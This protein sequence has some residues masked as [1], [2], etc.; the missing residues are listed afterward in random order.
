[1]PTEEE[2]NRAAESDTESKRRDPIF[3]PASTMQT[4]AKP[5]RRTEI[6]SQASITSEAT[7][8]FK[9]TPLA[10]TT[11][12]ESKHID[13][14]TVVIS[15]T[16]DEENTPMGLVITAKDGVVNVQDYL[17]T[18]STSIAAASE[19]RQVGLATVANAAGEAVTSS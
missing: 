1:M 3:S 4:V 17:H 11:L 19:S 7:V 5:K 2:G 8:G 12:P 15:I 14:D 6:L 10:T 16:T 9:A 13:L 18:V